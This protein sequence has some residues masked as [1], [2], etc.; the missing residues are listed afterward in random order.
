MFRFNYLVVTPSF[1]EYQVRR[2]EQMSFLCRRLYAN[3]IRP[4]LFNEWKN[5]TQV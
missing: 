2:G 3:T 1:L 4:V 5:G